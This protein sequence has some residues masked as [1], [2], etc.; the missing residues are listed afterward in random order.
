MT[1]RYVGPGGSDSNDGLSYADRKLTLNG[2][3][4]TPVVAGDTVYVAPGT[5][6][7][8]LTLDVTG[9][10]GSPITY[11]GDVTGAHTDLLGGTVVIS[12]SDDD[13]DI[14]RSS[15]IQWGANANYR[16]FRGLHIYR[17]TYSLYCVI[18]SYQMTDLIVED[19]YLGGD[20][21]LVI[22][23]NSG[24]NIPESFIF[25]RCISH[26]V[27]I[28]STVDRDTVDG[29]F[30]NC[31]FLPR[32]HGIGSPVYIQGYYNVTFNNCTLN[33]QGSN[34]VAVY[35]VSA[36]NDVYFYNCVGECC[37]FLSS[38]AECI[39]GDYNN[40]AHDRATV[41][42]TFTLGANTTEYTNL[43]TLPLLHH[44]KGLLYPFEQYAFSPE[45]GVPTL[46][47][48]SN[49]ASEDLF[50][51]TRP[52]TLSKRTRGAIQYNILEREATIVYGSSPVSYRMRD[53]QANQFIVPIT[54]KKMRFSCRVYRESDYA[55]TLP[56]VI[57]KQYGQSDV[58][59]TDTGSAETW[60]ELATSI[61]PADF[62]LFIAIEIRSNN[63][64]TSGDYKVYW[65][66]LEAN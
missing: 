49:S 29:L 9:S 56:Q 13:I 62:P 48:N 25:R 57:I 42:T 3:E 21:G 7:E 2:V 23:S 50:G 14:D 63:T 51:I 64:A 30:E 65:D 27:S 1:T 60:N 31:L 16:T 39:V 52:A 59:L 37:F 5:Y 22:P 10:S 34:S 43:F 54:G 26:G 66:V 19:C 58:T 61:T 44:E 46:A 15:G 40:F 32:L 8:T 35:M 12:G 17:A 4:D 45:S 24:A 38:P 18:S 53:A 28:R 11:I 33:P 47:C 55:G 41:S 6:R 20:Y 36:A